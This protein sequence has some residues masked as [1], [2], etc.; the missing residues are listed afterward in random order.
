M[1][2]RLLLADDHL[3]V[4]SGLRAMLEGE[5]E[6]IGVAGDGQSLIGAAFRL[7]PD[8]IILDISMPVLN[9]IDAARQ[10]KQAWPEAKM[11]FLSMHKNPGYLQEALN[12]G[13]LGYVLKSSAGEELQTAIRSVL[14][15]QIYIAPEFG[16]DAVT[17]RLAP[18][19]R[20]RRLS[21]KL[22]VRQQEVLRLIAEGRTNKEMAAILDVSVKTVEFHRGRI[23]SKLGVHTS[24][25]VATFAVRQGCTMDDYGNRNR[26]GR[27]HAPR[28]S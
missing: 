16:A 6:V 24:A 4:L 14:N 28:H 18:S 8:L 23:M 5:N 17:S 10:I 27:R 26:P 7:R 13:G 25:E 19:G 11:L 15:G 20:K 2:P 21:T 9:G 1:R 3:V 12:A 22:T